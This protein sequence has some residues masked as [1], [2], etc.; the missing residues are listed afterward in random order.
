MDAGELTLE[1]ITQTCGVSR[2][3]VY[4]WRMQAQGK[5]VT[6]A[7]WRAKAQFAEVVVSEDDQPSAAAIAPL[8]QITVSGSRTEI[9]LP[10]DYPVSDLVQIIR[11]LEAPDTAGVG[12]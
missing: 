1:Q 10:G 8:D 6:A 7:E 12:S 9:T 4:Q 2:S 5:P 11:V 3:Y